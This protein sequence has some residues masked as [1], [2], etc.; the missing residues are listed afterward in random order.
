M[1]SGIF[2]INTDGSLVELQETKYES[3]TVLQELLANYPSV[4]S[5][6]KS[7]GDSPVSWVLIRREMGIPAIREGGNRWSVD[8]LFLDREGI[9]TLVEVKRSSDTRLRREVIGQML[10]YAANAVVYWS[11]AKIHSEIEKTAVARGEDIGQYLQQLLGDIG[12]VNEYWQRVSANLISGRIRLILVADDI[13]DEMV[14]IIEFLNKQMAPAEIF[15]VEVKQFK[16]QGI[17]TLVPRIVG[18]SVEVEMRKKVQGLDRIQWNAESFLA[19]LKARSSQ[20]EYRYA[21]QI[22]NWAQRRK[23]RVW[24]GFGTEVGSFYPMLDLDKSHWMFDVRTGWKNA[25]IELTFAKYQS[26]FDTVEMKRELAERIFQATNVE[27]SEPSFTKY[28]SI[29]FSSLDE[30]KLHAFLNVF[31]WY[32]DIC[33]K[34]IFKPEAE[35]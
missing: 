35:K 3:E 15:A 23:L 14:H 12:D 19:V 17:T 32:I 21:E 33:K 5:G 20:I 13:P 16:G 24:W 2:L 27:I 8:H 28:P 10:D 9:P 1:P 6:N 22:L 34:S 11:V 7:S 25:F 31:D 30:G 18:T 4:L 29:Q 26:P